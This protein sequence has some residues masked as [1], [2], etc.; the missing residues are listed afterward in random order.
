LSSGDNTCERGSDG[1]GGE[2]LHLCV[3]GVRS[4]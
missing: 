4:D 3:V 1:C 2:A